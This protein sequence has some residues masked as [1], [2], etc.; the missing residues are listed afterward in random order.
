MAGCDRE[1]VALQLKLVMINAMIAL[2]ACTCL[3]LLDVHLRFE[4]ELCRIPDSN[5][6]PLA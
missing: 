1:R 3:Q 2:T 4:F 6:N 5:S